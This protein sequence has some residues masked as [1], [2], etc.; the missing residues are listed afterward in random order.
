LF[1]CLAS[2]LSVG[3]IAGCQQPAGNMEAKGPPPRPAELN[4][5]NPWV[6]TWNG[7]GEITVHT[8]KGPQTMKTTGTEHWAWTCDNRYLMGN[9]E[10]S[11]VDKPDQKH[12]GMVMTAWDPKEKEFHSWEFMGDGTVNHGEMEYDAKAGYWKIEGKGTD[13]MTGQACRSGGTAKMVGDN[14]FE[15][16]F[17]MWDSLKLKKLMEGKGTNTKQ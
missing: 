8:S 15:W 14:T 1:R 16:N 7:T 10:W 17:T 5:L 12:M 2:I 3:V 4:Q 9:F 13:P 11:M 6:G